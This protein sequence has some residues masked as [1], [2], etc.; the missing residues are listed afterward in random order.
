VRSPDRR[1]L[2]TDSALILA[3]TGGKP[4]VITGVGRGESDYFEAIRQALPRAMQ[5]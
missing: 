3:Q 1:R 5:A 4:L 2:I